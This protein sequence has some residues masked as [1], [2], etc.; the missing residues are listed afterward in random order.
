MKG[1]ILAA[2]LGT[3][4][5]PITKCISK[6]LLP[7]YNK[8]MIYYPLS[9]L[10][11]GGIKEILIITSDH[12]S[13][14]FKK[15]L[16]DG[17]SLGLQ[18]SYLIQKEPKGIAEAFII[19]E[20]FIKDDSVCL[21]LGDNIFYGNEMPD[22]VKGVIANVESGR[23]SAVVFGYPVKNPKSY[24]VAVTNKTGMVTDIQ[25]KPDNPSSDCAV[26]GLYMYDNTCVDRA[27]SLKP[28]KRGE[29]EI[30]DLNKLYMKDGKL[31]LEML[32]RGHAWF[33]TGTFES[34]YEASSFVRSVEN[35][36]GLMISNVHEIAYRFGYI[37]RKSLDIFIKSCGKN[38]Y[39]DYLQKLIEEV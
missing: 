14:S 16:G 3:R 18:I 4:L 28:S 5:Y 12:E 24:G 1:I 17:S 34:F 13:E 22:L 11:F 39:K 20:D 37:T 23:E 19:G 26:T 38:D 7:I 6:Q 36:Q 35:R 2:G 30:T 9:I 10:M 31:K 29:I 32:G 8:P 15:L 21:V 33:D 25:E 27:K